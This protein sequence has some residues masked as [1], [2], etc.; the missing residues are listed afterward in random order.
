MPSVKYTIFKQEIADSFVHG[1]FNICKT[2]IAIT[3]DAYVNLFSALL[4]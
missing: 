2:C 4:K 3:R 1:L